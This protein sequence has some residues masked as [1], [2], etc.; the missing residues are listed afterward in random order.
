MKNNNVFFQIVNKH[1]IKKKFN[2]NI[3][4]TFYLSLDKGE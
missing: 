3:Y 4:P 2:R 1:L